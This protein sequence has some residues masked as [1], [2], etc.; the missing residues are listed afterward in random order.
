M[1]DFAKEQTPLRNQITDLYRIDEATAINQ[2]ASQLDL[3]Q[4]SK[5]IEDWARQLISQVRSK[6]QKMAGVDALMHEFSLSSEE[7]VALMCLAEALLRVPDKQTQT[8]L[9][10]DK[11]SRGDW[12]SHVGQ[13]SSLF[14]NAAAWGL[15]LTGKLS[16]PANDQNLSSALNRMLS[17]GGE[18]MIRKGMD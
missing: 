5:Q 11:L 1:F 4:Q 13:G 10:R 7:G 17:K 18:P 3:S 14:V 12:K 2:L 8:L 15:L 9:I 16:Q 6:R